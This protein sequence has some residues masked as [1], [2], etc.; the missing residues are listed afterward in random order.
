MNFKFSLSWYRKYTIGFFFTVLIYFSLHYFVRGVRVE[1][2]NTQQLADIQSLINDSLLTDKRKAVKT[3][4]ETRFDFSGQQPDQ[5]NFL[6]SVMQGIDSARSDTTT[7]PQDSVA[8]KPIDSTGK[9]RQQGRGI[10]LARRD[11]PAARALEKLLDQLDDAH[12][13]IQFLTNYPLKVKSY[14]WFNESSLYWEI[15][16]WTWFGIFANL[17]FNVSEAL[18][19]NDFRK[20]EE[21][22]HFA[23]FIYGPPCSLIIYFSLD[24][25]ITNQDISF[26]SIEYGTIV[27]SFL[28]GFYSRKS[29]E[30]ID[31]IKNF[32]FA[33]KT[34][35]EEDKSIFM[36]EV[37]D[38][39]VQD[40]LNAKAE[41]WKQ[42]YPYVIEFRPTAK[43][44]EDGKPVVQ[45][46]TA[47]VAEK[48]AGLTKLFPKTLF[49]VAGDNKIVKI[50]TDLN[51]VKEEAAP[52]DPEPET[53]G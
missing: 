48:D 10:R 39:H 34:A 32:V 36:T 43:I 42:Q 14:F 35:D 51:F 50:Q 11:H 12:Y 30:L 44:P 23:K 49:Y 26:D 3:Y 33:S 29:I 38:K 7:P 52:A 17:F 15:I 31:K 27:L 41:L 28:L 20:E 45:R 6:G 19:K 37:T 40:A 1:Y 24:K 8:S 5:Y 9:P 4:L 2:L 25:L 13:N 22:V 18:S 21:Y 16:F 47:D 46:I 53:L